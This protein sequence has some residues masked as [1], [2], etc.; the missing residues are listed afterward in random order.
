MLFL[1]GIVRGR[2]QASQAPSEQRFIRPIGNNCYG[3]GCQSGV[4]RISGCQCTP[5]D[6]EERFSLKYLFRKVICTLNKL[7][8]SF[9]RRPES[10]N[11]N[12]LEPCPRRGDDLF[13]VSLR[14]MDI[15]CVNFILHDIVSCL[16]LARMAHVEV[17]RVREV[18]SI[19]HSGRSRA[20]TR[21]PVPVNQPGYGFRLVPE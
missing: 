16:L 20:G 1:H 6:R 13:R 2:M 8:S 10:T 12:K 11:I 21:N 18:W 4:V 9:R 17:H 5:D 14:E 3:E 7:D 15:C 19:R